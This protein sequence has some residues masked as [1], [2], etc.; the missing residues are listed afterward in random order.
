MSS[1][2]FVKAKDFKPTTVKYAPPKVTS[3]G[4]K[5]VQIKLNDRN[6]V[7]QIP[8]MLTWGSNER[9]N[10]EGRV[11]G[12]DLALQ[13][14]PDKFPAQRAMLDN[15]K[16]FQDKILNDCVKNS[17]EW[18]GKSKMT[19]EVVEALFYPILKYP[20]EKLGNNQWGDPDYTRNPTMK[21]KIPYW[22]GSWNTE[23]YDMKGKLL[24]KPSK[25]GNTFE[26]EGTPH[27]LIP[28]GSYIRGLIQCNGL[29]FTGGK[30]GLTWK[31]VQSC[32]EPPTY[33]VGSGKCQIDLVDSDDEDALDSIRS[34][35]AKKTEDVAPYKPEEHNSGPTFDDDDDEE[36][37]VEEE[38]E[39]EEEEEVKPEPVKKKKTVRK[40]KV[41]KNV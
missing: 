22:E 7:L 9:S 10:D 2:K 30:C 26:C 11:T 39:E 15:V 34:K 37:V 14:E 36:E 40:K 38:E 32:V 6:L 20:K 21:I 23:V 35:A 3:R 24:Y 33:L 31:L 8:V 41:K 25:N 27:S 17:R 29:W 4:G 16:E 18:F 28:K 12:Y 19:K 13:F 5:D 1:V